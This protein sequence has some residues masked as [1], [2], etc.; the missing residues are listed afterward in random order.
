MALIQIRTASTQSEEFAFNGILVP[1]SYAY[2]D[3]DKLLSQALINI[4]HG[5]N[6]G[7]LEVGPDSPNAVND[8]YAHIQLNTPNTEIILTEDPYD[9]LGNVVRFL[10]AKDDSIGRDGDILVVTTDYKM[11]KRENGVYVF[12]F[13]MQG[14]TGVAVAAQ[15]WFSTYINNSLGT[16]GDLLLLPTGALYKKVSG[17]YVY[18][19][20]IAGQPGADGIDGIDGTQIFLSTG[21][22]YSGAAN[23]NDLN[24]VDSTDLYKRIGPDWIYIG[25]IKGDKGLKGDKGDPGDDGYSPQFYVTDTYTNALGNDNDV[26]L[27]PVTFEI[28]KKVTGAWSYQATLDTPEGSIWRYNATV[29]DNLGKDGDWLLIAGGDV[30]ERVGGTYTL[31]TN[32]KGDTGDTGATGPAGTDGTD[33]A[34]GIDGSQIYFN[35][36]VD[37]GIG[38]DGDILIVG[39]QAYKKVGGTYVYQ[40]DVGTEASGAGFLDW[41]II[42]NTAQITMTPSYVLE[43][44]IGEVDALATTT[45]SISSGSV[46]VPIGGHQ[47]KLALSA[48]VSCKFFVK[49]K[50]G[51]T[52][53]LEKYV[54][55]KT[56][57][58]DRYFYVDA[59]TPVEVYFKSVESAQIPIG[60]MH[61]EILQIKPDGD[62]TNIPSLIDIDETSCKRKNRIQINA[63]TATTTLNL[64]STEQYADIIDVNLLS[65]TTI[66]VSNGLIDGKRLTI[67]VKQ[68]DTTTRTYSFST[69]NF[70]LD[71]LVALDDLVYSTELSAIDMIGLKYDLT[72]SKWKVLS[73]VKEV[74]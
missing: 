46:T 60:G 6:I 43:T 67:Y 38:Q 28:Y 74:Y 13:Q 25:S 49:V 24:I 20:T 23:E 70:L 71:N 14:G 72:Q 21:G 5:I 42:E 48:E 33:G 47:L 61:L 45:I 17:T 73:Y 66:T 29:D 37:D 16:D 56:F 11:Y 27:N 68:D 36:T 55:A 19:M 59:A 31:K 1:F 4:Y 69:T 53:L 22:T 63:T 50:V 9:A 57:T 58:F 40:G 44:N 62:V 12:K 8:I 34:D 52:T 51:L 54:N 15:W 32:I 18:Q 64:N 39:I 26:L 3:V 30:Y 2:Y 41:A 10:A 7:A 65:D 35:P